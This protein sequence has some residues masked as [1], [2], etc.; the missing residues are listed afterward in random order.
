MKSIRSFPFLIVGLYAQWDLNILQRGEKLYDETREKTIE[1]YRNTLESFVDE[2]LSVKRLR[3]RHFKEA[4]NRSLE[5]I[6]E[7][8]D[9]AQQM[10]MLPD[11]AWLRRDKQDAKEE[12]HTLFENIVDALIGK[13]L[14]KEQDK[15]AE[16]KR[17]IAENDAKIARYKEAKIGAPVK[18]V[19]YTTKSEYDEKI[20]ALKEENKALRKDIAYLKKRFADYF[21]H[22]GISLDAEQVDVLLTRVDGEDLI[23]LTSVL[24]TLGYITRQLG[25]LMK[26]SGESLDLAKRYYAM[27]EV[28]LELTLYLQQH[29]VDRCNDVYLAKL[30]SIKKQTADTIEKTLLLIKEEEDSDRRAIYKRNLEALR[31]TLETAKRYEIDLVRSRDAVQKAMQTTRKNLQVAQNT[32]ETVTLSSELYDLI[33]KNRTLFKKIG[34]IQLPQIIPFD[35]LQI[36]KRYNEIT[37][38]LR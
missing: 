26:E 19:V 10:R 11:S 2:N 25:K 15:L 7:A 20:E 34:Q 33:S 28:L 35:N 31:L 18:S 6:A 5:D 22:M 17:H 27:H 29:Y 21:A 3:E 37:Q 12:L 24:D 1:I 32:Y 8:A 30:D 38:K 14:R 16:I 36:K 23:R 9:I 4:W 13:N